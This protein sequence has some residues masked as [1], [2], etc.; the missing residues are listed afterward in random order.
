MALLYCVLVFGLGILL[1]SWVWQLGWT[2]CETPA[3]LWLIPL[4]L[5]PLTPRL[6]R[7]APAPA[8]LR[9]PVE[10]GFA[11][12]SPPGLAPGTAAALALC[13]LVGSLRYA[14]HPL[15]PC[16]TPHDLATYNLPAGRAFDRSAPQV[17]VEGTVSAYP[18]I[19]DRRQRLV[20]AAQTLTVAGVTQP[21]EGRLQ[22]NTGIRTRYRYGDTL[23]VAGRLAT[24]PDFE[25]FS[26]REYLARRGVHS[27]MAG[28]RVEA[29]AAP[30]AGSRLLRAVYGLRAHGEALI[31]RQLPEP[32][33]GLA[34]GMLLGVEAGIPDDLYDQF[35]ATGAS[36]V[37]VISGSNVALLAGVLL[38]VGGRLLGRRRAA[39]PALA[40]VAAF[41]LLVG[42]D[43]AVVRAALM[44]G[45]VIAAAALGRRSTALVSLA[46]AAGAM[47]LANPLILWDVG[48]QLSS[49]A[50][51]GLILLAPGLTRA[52]RRVWPHFSGG[53]LAG[54]APAPGNAGSAMRGLLEDGLVLTLAASLAT[55]PLTAYHFGRFS[56]IGLVTNVLIAPVQPAILLAGS[57]AVLVG[58][59]G[60]T[61]L[62]QALF[63]LPWL[64]LAWTVLAVRWTAELPGAGIAVE[65]FGLAAL[66][67]SYGLLAAL[68]WRGRIL[69]A[70]RSWRPSLAR[71]AGPAAAGGVA[72]VA[73]LIWAA[74][75]SQPDGR[76][77]LYFLDVGQG[78][79]VLVQTP[80]GRQVLIDGG[81]SPQALFAELG[82]AMP[83]WDRS[84]D[85]L[86]L[87]HPDGDHMAAQTELPRRF[88]V[89][90][91]VAARHVV[92]DKAA[93]P[94][95][96]ALAAAGIPLGVQGR[97]GWIDLGDGVALWVLWPDDA[98]ASGK[99]ADTTDNDGSLVV[100]LVYGDF[101]A[102]L[103]GDAGS[104]VEAALLAQGAPLPA[105]V[106]KVAHHGSQ[107]STTP[108]FVRAVNPALAVIQVG[109]DNDYG[110]PHTET[111]AAL[112]GRTVLRTDEQGRVHI[113]T[114]GARIWVESERPP[115]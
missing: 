73:L 15:A 9:W 64:A 97:G 41:A 27:Q 66:G 107:G 91:A 101:S 96:D 109:L 69:A 8:P 51:A 93:A 67:A 76:L 98:P 103:T 74:A 16:W 2:G 105:T 10:A 72:I 102:L 35:N 29:V 46:A 90:Q 40:G 25:D 50:T 54:S 33:A 13:L 32:Y 7:A 39:L 111:L 20:L 80:S 60:L 70:L 36:H 31:N 47:A 75:L 28:V 114:D 81:A 34:N 57:A 71:L 6:K 68:L 49:A 30:P 79:G 56:L 99:Q 24:P 95:R 108:A 112:G 100:R 45:M 94:W 17:T 44:G 78:D 38:A 62:S 89:G 92:A 77:H 21:V 3:W 19:E 37:I 106:L 110:H 85:L 5:L 52:L 4:A 14:A 22:F 48:F 61:L 87:T 104:A 88:S 43:A 82:A 42:G 63:W 86:L 1:G 65:G 53:L 83:F 55:F 12:I 23:R 115:L 18:V 58:V 113:A 59:A 11:P 26:Y 84:L